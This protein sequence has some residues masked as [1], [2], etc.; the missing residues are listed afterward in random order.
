MPGSGATTGDKAGAVMSLVG[1]R[2]C[3]GPL[4]GG[5]TVF[6]RDTGC[7]LERTGANEL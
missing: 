5:W 1:T 3:L 7:R 2:H 4:P 6:V